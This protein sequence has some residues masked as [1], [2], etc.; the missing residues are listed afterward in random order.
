MHDV[1][2]KT[3]IRRNKPSA[4][5]RSILSAIKFNQPDKIDWL[6]YGCGKGDDVRHLKSLGFNVTGY[7]PFHAPIKLGNKKYSFVSCTYVLN[8][9]DSNTRL[10]VLKNIIKRL[11][12]PGLAL[13]TVRRD[14]KTEGV[15]KTGT[16]QWN[17]KLPFLSLARNSQYETYIATKDEL[18]KEVA[19][20]T[21]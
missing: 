13:I 16:Q 20:S 6:D 1:S 10:E 5:L 12:N 21:P 2:Y 19:I 14:I 18:E 17:V 15:T 11:R 8:V 9:L 4:P 7:D 3:A